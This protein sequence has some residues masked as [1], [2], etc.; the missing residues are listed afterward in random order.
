MLKPQ[1]QDKMVHILGNHP[2]YRKQV[3]CEVKR[4][5]LPWK[6]VILPLL[7]NLQKWVWYVGMYPFRV[8]Y[9]SLCP[10]Y[11]D[12]KCALIGALKSCTLHMHQRSLSKTQIRRTGNNVVAPWSLLPRVSKKEAKRL[13]RQNPEIFSSSLEREREIWNDSWCVHGDMEGKMASRR[14]LRERTGRAGGVCTLALS[15]ERK[16]ERENDRHSF[17]L[18]NQMPKVWS[19]IK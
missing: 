15:R 3:Q 13:K 6:K 19:K 9:L 11:N 14:W 1:C 7:Q 17:T 12:E 2:T 10:L 8:S 5:H 16:R 4:K 18:A